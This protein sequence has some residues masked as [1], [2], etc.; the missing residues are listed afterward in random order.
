MSSKGHTQV[1]GQAVRARIANAIMTLPIEKPKP[2]L[3]CSVHVVGPNGKIR[4]CNKTAL[5]EVKG[6]G[7]C[8]LKEHTLLAFQRQREEF[9]MQRL[10]K[11]TIKRYDSIAIL[12]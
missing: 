11:K 1:K 4:T 6:E 7:F 3:R 5:R 12:H 2:A 8:G 9:R 10:T